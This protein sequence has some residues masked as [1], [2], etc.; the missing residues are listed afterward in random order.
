MGQLLS[1]VWGQQ[2]LPKSAEQG[3]IWQP[4][5]FPPSQPEARQLGSTE[6]APAPHGLGQ[7]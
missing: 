5:P 7:G 1:G 4:G 2:G 3:R 6:A